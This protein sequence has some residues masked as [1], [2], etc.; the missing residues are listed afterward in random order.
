MVTQSPATL[1][2]ALTLWGRF[3][4]A[5]LVGTHGLGLGLGLAKP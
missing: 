1:A 3:G 4:P 2:V 5:G